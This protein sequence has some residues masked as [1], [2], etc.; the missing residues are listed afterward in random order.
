MAK[1]QRADPDL[2]SR[3]DSFLKMLELEKR[4]KLQRTQGHAFPTTAS[5]SI[6]PPSAQPNKPF[7]ARRASGHP[8]LS[9][10][11][12]I[13]KAVRRSSALPSLSISIPP[14]SADGPVAEPDGFVKEPQPK[15]ERTKTVTFSG[16]DKGDDGDSSDQS[17]ICQSPSWEHYG[18]KK[19]KPKKRDAEK[20]KD[21]KPAGPLKKKGNRLSKVPPSKPQEAELPGTEKRSHS[22]PELDLNSKSDRANQVAAD[23]VRSNTMSNPKLQGQQKSRGFFSSFRLQHGN[24]AAVQKVI[25]SRRMDSDGGRSAASPMLQPH[26]ALSGAD[27]SFANPRKPPSVGSAV[28]NSTRSISSLDQLPPTVHNSSSSGHGRSQSLLSSTLSKLRGPSYLYYRPAGGTDNKHQ[29]PSSSHDVEI[30]GNWSK[31]RPVGPPTNTAQRLPTFTFPPKPKRAATQPTADTIPRNTQDKV[32]LREAEESRE[33]G[34]AYESPQTVSFR[35]RHSKLPHTPAPSQEV[36][37]E[38]EIRPRP[39]RASRP[40]GHPV[41]SPENFD[42][43]PPPQPRQSNLEHGGQH[44]TRR[45]TMAYESPQAKVSAESE[46]TPRKPPSGRRDNEIN[47]DQLNGSEPVYD[48]EEEG[49]YE[50]D[51]VSTGTHSS[52]TRPLPQR[53]AQASSEPNGV[54]HVTFPPSPSMIGRAVTFQGVEEH[55]EQRMVVEPPKAEQ[56]ASMGKTARTEKPSRSEKSSDYFSFVSQSYAP[57]PLELRPPIDSKFPSTRI[58]EEPEEGELKHVLKN[59]PIKV[60]VNKMLAFA[61]NTSQASISS[62]SPTTRATIQKLP[63]DSPS[64][65]SNYSDS[66]VPPFERL[67][68]SQKVARVLT[69]TES[70]STSASQSN[71]EPSRAT[72]ERSSSSTCDDTPPTPDSPPPQSHQ[73]DVKDRSMDLRNNEQRASRRTYHPPTVESFPKHNSRPVSRDGDIQDD[74]WSRTALPIDL[75]NHSEASEAN[76]LSG[77]APG[78]QLAGSPGPRILEDDAKENPNEEAPS[79][80]NLYQY[81][82]PPRAY[83]AIDLHS[84][85]SLPNSKHPLLY[86]KKSK[87]VV[88][89]TSL[90]NSSS[91]ELTDAVTPRKS[92]LRTS[93]KSSP[94]SDDSSSALV[95][96]G[97]A[98][99]L[100]EARKA[101]PMPPPAVSTARAL[102]SHH[103]QKAPAGVV[104]GGG[105]EPGSSGAPAAAENGRS[106]PLA[107]MLVECCSCKFFHDMPSR[108]YECMAKPDSLV[109]DKLLGVSATI[110]TMVRCPWC[111]HGM[112]TACCAGYAAVVYLK[113][114]LHGK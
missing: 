69:A 57:P 84:V 47:D 66:D 45:R 13:M 63:K 30:A 25:E 71:T 4:Y 102:R 49:A 74:G 59:L 114:K 68:V 76:N 83:S 48:K 17:S 94:R 85:G 51:Q 43:L 78:L 8:P 24:F 92:A 53:Q 112:S 79:T 106:E 46:R 9:H 97:A 77:M 23:Q 28:S 35:S 6:S 103:V 50:E 82:M 80:G 67:G 54:K 73:E 81:T 52:T 89:P 1:V 15:E 110:T 109:E 65:S 5:P 99:Y 56:P 12:Q 104:G 96:S 86:P 26:P 20:G 31:D 37:V 55:V 72:S 22:V 93:H 10:Q 64:M 29:R 36:A 11:T 58:D 33:K 27:P 14:L 34:N 90:P 61:E 105:R 75:D 7:K 95:S 111:G 88:S 60:Q 16:P 107:K 62:S 21:E 44:H 101:A 2:R 91:P 38:K 19:K 100:Q 41:E 32:V 70:S 3:S 87:G 40:T 42:G 98:S 113:E 108:V 39:E 18:R